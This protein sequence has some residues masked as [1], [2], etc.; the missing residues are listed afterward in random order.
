MAS[1]PRKLARAI[2][3]GAR[4][5]V[6]EFQ[7]RR[8]SPFGAARFEQRTPSHANAIEIFSGRWATDLSE[9]DPAW[10]GGGA[11]LT[12]DPRPDFAAQY[13]GDE[14]FLR[15]MTV[16]EL[17]PLEGAHTYRLQQLGAGRILAIESNVEAYLKC[18]M[19]KEALGMK[20]AEFMLGDFTLYLQE[21]TERFDLVFCC[22]VLYHMQDPLRLI[23]DIA[24][25][26]DRCLVW[27]HYFDESRGEVRVA[28]PASLDGIASTYYRAQ[29]RDRAQP[30]FWGGNKPSASW[31]TRD[32][33]LGAFRHFGLDDIKI[34]AEDSDAPH[35]PT[36]C[37]AARRT[38]GG[39]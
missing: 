9:F 26:S 11:K 19:V 17:G 37:F 32:D 27:T 31:M 36:T 35:G 22:G 1:Y 13:L 39:Q 6:R 18:L 21:C 15:G 3:T 12:K 4:I 38:G 10:H 33:I 8:K 14:G 5:A 16:L 20:R 25:V 7:A 29:Y 2:V 30:S 23:R 34:I 24:R 28:V